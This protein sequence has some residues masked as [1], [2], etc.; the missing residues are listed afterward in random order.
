M[1]TRAEFLIAPRLIRYAD[2]ASMNVGGFHSATAAETPAEYFILLENDPFEPT[3]ADAPV[4][5]PHGFTL[6][7]ERR[8]ERGGSAGH[9]C[10]TAEVLIIHTGRWRL[11]V[12][13]DAD[14]STDLVP[15]DVVSIPP[16][17]LRR[18]ER[19]D[20]EAGFLFIVQGSNAGTPDDG[21]AVSESVAD[22]RRW[23]RD[24]RFIDYSSGTPRLR[25]VAGGRDQS[26]MR[27]DAL[28]P[29]RIN[30]RQLT[31]CESSAL[32][33]RGVAE[34]GIISPPVTRDG[35][36]KGA[37]ETQWPHGFNLRSLMLHSGAYV[38][39]HRRAETE[40]VLVQTGT[41][42]VSWAEV[43]TMLGAGDVLSMP[44]GVPHALRNTTSQP[45]EAF[46]VRGSDDP[47]MPQ[48]DSMPTLEVLK[49]TYTSAR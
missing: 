37:I 34:A 48:F 6:K 3:A 35:F 11:T 9:K 43:A 33:L 24:G 23:V 47:A 18:W 22:E 14:V 17:L 45:V 21:T 5:L 32:S 16:D 4:G 28:A 38:P 20:G 39:R 10:A 42:E 46:V 26:A 30:A 1:R 41:L 31:P 13:P 19:L 44:A 27:G 15:G 8:V 36:A 29:Y 12:G 7:G 40:V 49:S 25:E 2:L